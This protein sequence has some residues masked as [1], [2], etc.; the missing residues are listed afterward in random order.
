V[1]L[2]VYR[3]G[4]QKASLPIDESTIFVHK[5]M[6]EHKVLCNSIV[7]EPA[8]IQIGD[9]IEHDSERFYINTAPRVKK[10][11]NIT[12]EYNI[13][14]EGEVYFLYN[15]LYLDEVDADFSYSGQ[16]SDFLQ[17]LVSNIN[18]IQ[19]GWSIGG[20]TPAELQTL[21]FSGDS[22]RTA[23]TKIAQA[24]DM[25]YRLIGKAI[26]MFR[27]VT[28]PTIYRFEYGRGKGLYTLERSSID[29]NNLVT[30]AYG[31]GSR[32][33]IGVDYR[34]GANRLTF[35]EKYL[36]NNVALYGIREGSLLLDD[37]FP[38]RTGTVSSINA[39]DPLE[40]TDGNLDFDIN[41]YLIEGTV[42]KVVFKSGDLSGYEFEIKSY[43]NS[44]KKVVFLPF[45]EE[46]GFVLPNAQNRPRV[47]DTYTLV[48][49]KMPQSYIDDAEAELKS[50]T[51]D[52]IDE[53]SVPRVTYAITIDEKH[54][55]DNGVK[56]RPWNSVNI[57]DTE[58]GIDA[59]IR[60]TEVSYPLLFPDRI[61]GTIS[62][63]LT[64]TVQERL[65]ANTINNGTIVKNVDL[66]RA[67]LSRRTA[68]R[69]RELQ[70]L[71]FDPDGYF[72]GT[73]LRPN[74]V[75]TLYLSVGAK[76][77]N[78]GLNGVAIEPNAQADP[79]RL[80]ITAGKLVHY[81]IEIDGLGYIWDLPART[82]Q[83]LTPGSA[84][85]VY[86]Q[87]SK[88]ALTGT[89]EISVQPV[90]T[91][92]VVGQ[93]NFNVGILYAVKDGRRD[94]DF[95]NGMTYISGDTITTGKIKS[96]DGL[97]FFDL[98][99]GQFKVGNI[100]H[101]LD[102][103]VTNPDRL[104]I[105]GSIL[106]TSAGED[107]DLPNYRG[108]YSATTDYFKGDTVTYF[109]SV[110]FNLTEQ[111]TN[112]ISPSNTA[113]WR[114]Y[115]SSGEDGQDGAVGPSIV[116]RGQHSSS[117]VYYNNPKRRDVVKFEGTYYLFDGNDATSGSFTLANWE[118]FGAQFESVATNLLLAENANI[119]DFILKSGKISSQTELGGTPLLVLD[120]TDG[121]I[122]MVG[123]NEIL[124]SGLNPPAS[125]TKILTSIVPIVGRFESVHL[126]TS[127][128][129]GG[130][131]RLESKGIIA[132]YAGQKTGLDNYVGAIYA[133]AEAKLDII[134]D[135]NSCGVVGVYGRASNTNGT[136]TGTAPSFGGLFY[137]L[138]VKGLFLQTQII[139]GS[140]DIQ[141]S[142]T[143]VHFKDGD[144]QLPFVKTG[145]YGHTIF[146]MAEGLGEF[147]K[148]PTA[149]QPDIKVLNTGAVGNQ[150][151]FSNT[152]AIA[153][154]TDGFWLVMRF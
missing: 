42:A 142:T 132:D 24:F 98:S 136:G 78:F 88:A 103:N 123:E 96:L 150:V 46:S 146:A 114:L 101:S 76:S 64:Y 11:N 99:N 49:I 35:Q 133:A 37:V 26:Y 131:A 17:L 118:S 60:M 89:W 54:V 143:F 72:D 3:N 56:I 43:S 149:S 34:A 12:Y 113:H 139:A 74:S 65:I 13:I 1:G 100:D 153:T 50:R 115:V 154:Y 130:K 148:F 28:V 85:Y 18:S 41:D 140:Q 127:N 112:N 70:D 116:Y 152:M 44:N 30:R 91:E 77:Q 45:T 19:P 135:L 16:P 105:R 97:N 119:A 66:R 90:T 52:Y 2:E 29:R 109:G 15:K 120:G 67:E 110:Y 79:N 95:T 25:E 93:Y 102:W 8:D 48:D 111:A 129:P 10:I 124:T 94:F 59:D 4:A 22:C 5:L 55:R 151:S 23:L 83:N 33:N 134:G 107:I 86:A 57:T 61:S 7:A 68:S 141:P 87:C 63:T 92:A 47:G 138:L 121:D 126:S 36:E 80:A 145:V 9:Y 62:D 40:F 51:Q 32:R 81:E 137:D 75:E 84:Y 108:Q 82:F 144:G 147:S 58:L 6:G 69:F 122:R 128:Q 21:G 53:N 106:Q 27:T 38:Q 125:P 117:A 39:S 20:A 71:V 14:F 31:Y 104:T 73:N